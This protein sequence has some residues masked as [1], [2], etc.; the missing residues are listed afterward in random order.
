M[1]MTKDERE[2][3]DEHRDETKEIMIRL[4]KIEIWVK[5]AAIAAA[6]SIAGGNI[7]ADTLKALA[8]L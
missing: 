7:G 3:C 1:N 4:T 8:G 2:R 6:A 5:I